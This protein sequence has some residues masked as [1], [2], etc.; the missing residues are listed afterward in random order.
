[1][2]DEEGPISFFDKVTL[3]ER[4]SRSIKN[5]VD[6]FLFNGIKD[7]K[8]INKK[9]LFKKKHFIMGNPKFDLVKNSCNKIHFK[10]INL[11]KKKYNKFL[12]ITGHFSMSQLEP[13]NVKK[14]LESANAYSLSSFNSKMKMIA[15]VIS[16]S[17]IKTSG[18]TQPK[19]PRNTLN[20]E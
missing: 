16:G 6:Y 1:M 19:R 20:I 4:Y 9:F 14:S 11:I 15:I 5:Q 3:K 12:F 2:L 18:L 7:I 10:E 8:K 17:I 13:N